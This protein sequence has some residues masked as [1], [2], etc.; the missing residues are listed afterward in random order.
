MSIDGSL[1]FL[2]ADQVEEAAVAAG[3]DEATTAALVEDYEAAQIQSLKT[4][5]LVAAFIVLGTLR[6]HSE[7]PEPASRRASGARARPGLTIPAI[8]TAE[9]S[10][11]DPSLT[12]A[13]GRPGF[14]LMNRTGVLFCP[15]T[16]C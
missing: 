13:L 9:L 12:P 1:D 14:P 5:L 15:G 16:E 7:P 6:V 11:R 8:A 2:T 3:L 10:G 4:G